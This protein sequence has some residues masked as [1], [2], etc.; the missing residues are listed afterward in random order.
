MFQCLVAR[1]SFHFSFLGCLFGAYQ[2]VLRRR[3]I[4]TKCSQKGPLISMPKKPLKRPLNY[5]TTT[6]TTTNNNNNNNNK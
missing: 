2:A 1:F 5:T 6:T 4:I 3:S